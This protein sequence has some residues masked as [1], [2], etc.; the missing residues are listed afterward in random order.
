VGLA[1]GGFLL[2]H[3]VCLDEWMSWRSPSTI[4]DLL[5]L[6]AGGFGSEVPSLDPL[7]VVVFGHA[8]AVLVHLW[9]ERYRPLSLRRGMRALAATIVLVWFAYYA[10]RPNA[11]CLSNLLVPYSFLLLDT[12]RVAILGRRRLWVGG[13]KLGLS[14][15]T[16][17]LIIVPH[18]VLV[19]RVQWWWYVDGLEHAFPRGVP[20]G[21][22][23][24]GARLPDDAR[25]Q[26]LLAQ[27]EF[28]RGHPPAEPL[29]YFTVDN[30]LVAGQARAW[31][32]VSL[33]LA[34]PFWG[35]LTA[36]HY[37]TL[38][39]SVLSPDVKRIYFDSWRGLSPAE[40]DGKPEVRQF[41]QQLRFDLSGTFVPRRTVAGWE[42]WVRR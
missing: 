34:N 6:F 38:L 39:F 41:Y 13:W 10:N 4:A 18:V 24:Q 29:I 9:I 27:G 1:V 22:L 28:L 15:A 23:V 33:P 30:L 20:S 21:R 37:R 12:L 35:T 16:L 31:P 26:R 14:A 25:T 36:E 3:R 11:G 40:A 19:A 17:A 42:E 5:F 7:A 8:G 2:L 32:D